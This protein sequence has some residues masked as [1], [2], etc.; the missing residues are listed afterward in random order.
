MK[1]LFFDVEC[2]NCFNGVG[3][4]CEFGYVL[5]DE[6]FKII[7]KDEIPMSPGKGKE[8]RFHLTGRKG[9][10]DIELGYDYKYYFSQPEFPHFYE[11]IKKLMTAQD[12]ICFAFAAENDVSHIHN[13]CKRYRLEPLNYQYYDI[14]KFAKSYLEDKE[15]TGLKAAFDRIVGK[16]YGVGLQEHSSSD[17]AKMTMMVFEA[18]CALEKTTSK[19]YLSLKKPMNSRGFMDYLAKKAQEK[20][21]RTKLYDDYINIAKKD[22]EGRNTDEIIGKRCIISGEIKRQEE[23]FNKAI[24]EIHKNG[25]VCV[26]KIN[27]SDFFLVKDEKNKNDIEKSLKEPYYGKFVILS[28]KE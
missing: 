24:S 26:L 11:K 9:Q 7:L 1:Y 3:K 14:Q 5:T 16:G 13:T 12:T 4:L 19:V 21:I 17:D 22:I 15:E 28:E 20:S 8:S 2:S 25:G 6:N 23:T 10:K 27:D 18:I